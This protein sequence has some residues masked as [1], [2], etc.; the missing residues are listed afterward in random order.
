MTILQ[1]GEWSN[2][3]WSRGKDNEYAKKHIYQVWSLVFRSV[4]EQRCL[5]CSQCK[6]Y[7]WN[8]FKRG[9]RLT[10][11]E[12][13][14]SESRPSGGKGRGCLKSFTEIAYIK[15]AQGRLSRTPAFHL[16]WYTWRN[17]STFPT[18]GKNNGSFF[19]FSS[20]IN[21]AL[22]LIFLWR[23]NSLCLSIWHQKCQQKVQSIGF[24]EGSVVLL[25]GKNG[26]WTGPNDV[27]TTPL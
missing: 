23:K 10:M 24:H 25:E 1:G 17:C 15:C 14:Y 4:A 22:E 6:S 8:R 26:H 21:F 7:I 11:N 12:E 9:S 13:K 20:L 27:K 19:S 18:R 16:L 5:W 3:I 2:R